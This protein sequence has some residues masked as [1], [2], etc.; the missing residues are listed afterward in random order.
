MYNMDSKLHQVYSLVVDCL[1]TCF[2]VVVSHDDSFQTW[3]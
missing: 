2:P 3:L 1:E